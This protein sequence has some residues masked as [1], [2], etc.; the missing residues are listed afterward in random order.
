MWTTS[1]HVKIKNGMSRRGASPSRIVP[2]KVIRVDS[3][4]IRS[5]GIWVFSRCRRPACNSIVF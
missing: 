2:D 1:K 5:K 3:K 4:A